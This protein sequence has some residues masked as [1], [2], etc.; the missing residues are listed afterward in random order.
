MYFK[1]LAY[2]VWLMNINNFR[3]AEIKATE[4]KQVGLQLSC[5]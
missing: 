2:G 5:D 4:N 1:K 3:L